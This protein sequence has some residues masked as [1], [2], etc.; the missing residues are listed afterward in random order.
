VWI[1]EFAENINK[2]DQHI[3]QIYSEQF[4]YFYLVTVVLNFDVETTE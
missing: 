3:I 2:N 4:S 1:S